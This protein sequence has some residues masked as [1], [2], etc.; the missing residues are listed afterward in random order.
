MVGNE[1]AAARWPFTS[2]SE[3]CTLERLRL[4]RAETER[5]ATKRGGGT[6]S[7]VTDGEARR[8]RTHFWEKPSLL[9]RCYPAW[10][11]RPALRL[12]ADRPRADAPPRLAQGQP[13]HAVQAEGE[14]DG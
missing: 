4:N 9:D 7:A 6:L 5:L 2:C 3:R 12:E 8:A 11:G 14:P 13:L 1:S 10:Q